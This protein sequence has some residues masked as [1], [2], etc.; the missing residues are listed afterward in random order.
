MVMT[1][2]QFSQIGWR[3]VCK[4]VKKAV[5]YIDN[6]GA[7]CLHWNGG[8]M[9]MMRAGAL[10]VK[11]FSAFESDKEEYK[12][13]VFILSSPVFG[14]T[15]IILQDIIQNSSFEYCVLI[16][17]ANA[18]VHQFAKYG[19]HQEGIDVMSIFHTLEEEMLEWMGNMDY[20][21]EVLYSPLFILPLTEMMFLTP[22]FRNVFPITDAH[23]PRIRELQHCQHKQV[24]KSQS[25]DSLSSVELTRL[26]LEA[27]ISV[28]HLVSCLHSLFIQLEI[29]EDIYSLGHLSG[30]VAN[31]LE[32]LP[33]A[34]NRRKTASNRCSLILIDRTL[35]LASVTTHN[36]ESLLDR[37]LAVLPRLPGHTSDV[38]VNM[39]PICDAKVSSP[40]GNIVL[41]PGCLAHP[42][43]DHCL[44]VL[45]WLVNKPQRDILLNLHH[46]LSTLAP[47]GGSDRVGKLT[48]VTPHTIDKQVAMFRGH[49]EAIYQCSGL[50]Q[51][52]LAVT[53]TLRS[54]RSSQLDTMVSIE[55]LLVQNLGC[56]KDGVGVLTQVTQLV[57]TRHERGLL[58]PDILGLLIHLF[59]LAGTDFLFPAIEQS[60]LLDALK[61]A[62][63]E[64]REQLQGNLSELVN[65]KAEDDFAEIA[66]DILSKLQY[67]ASARKDLV[68]YRTLLSQPNPSHPLAYHSLLHQLMADVLDPDCPDLPDLT[69]KSTGLKDFLK[70]GFSLLLNRPRQQHPLDNPQLILFILGGITAHEVKLIQDMVISSGQQTQVLVG[71]TRLLSPNDIVEAI[72]I[73]DPLMQQAL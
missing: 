70:S 45:E 67:I 22:T 11:E 62:L 16:T 33:D 15:K 35:D 71:G 4:K 73:K 18:R 24:V 66:A 72:F 42:N 8:L 21:V 43:F 10:T 26:P 40:L 6:E 63:Y 17:S 68:R 50:L 23:I 30:L 19:G 1:L 7:E 59:S 56:T 2:H 31:Q 36:T 65:S 64:D 54:P 48:R 61:L 69:C 47:G 20:T 49:T 58:M 41:T 60:H 12:K 51:Q 13:A 32:I 34:N 37:I 27:Q 14:T 38:A 5:V 3:E 39:S 55:K 46:H 25:L 29:R 57:R 9:Q 44:Q 53:Q 28:H 52:A